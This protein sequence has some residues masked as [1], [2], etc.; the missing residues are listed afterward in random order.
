MAEAQGTLP[1]HL[2]EQR[3]RAFVRSDAPAHTSTVESA[4]SYQA[5]GIDNSFTLDQFQRNFKVQVWSLDEEEM[6]FDLIGIDAALANAFRRILIAEV[7]TMAIDKVFVLN[8]TSMIQDEVLSQRLGLVPIR[9]D[10]RKFNGRQPEEDADADNV[11]SFRLQVKCTHARQPSGGASGGGASGAGSGGGASGG[12]ES[13]AV[14]ARVTSGNL[15]WIAQGDQDERFADDPIR[16]V[17]DDILLARLRPGQE[18]ELEAWCE[19]GLGKTHAKWS[20]VCTASYRLLPEVLVRPDE[21][22]DAAAAAAAAAAPPPSS[23]DVDGSAPAPARAAR[24]RPCTM[25]GAA[26]AAAGGAHAGGAPPLAGSGWEARVVM[27]RLKDHF[28]F[29]IESTGAMPPE[30]LFSEAVKVLMQKIIDIAGLLNDAT[31]V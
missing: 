24:P 11:I 14:N 28:I 9:A 16:P 25:G 31:A 23:F 19:K 13:D 27:S 17:H 8:N 1:A 29:S 2:E 20:P 18:V 5:C 6:V 4:G 22:A 30:L 12:S 3:R 21:A 7:P 10:P 15:E 26:G